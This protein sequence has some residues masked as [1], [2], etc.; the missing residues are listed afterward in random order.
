MASSRCP[1]ARA[2]ATTP[3]NGLPSVTEILGAVQLTGD[4]SGIAVDVLDA[5]RDRGSAVHAAVHDDVYHCLDEASLPPEVL[6]RVNGWRRFLKDSGYR[7]ILAEGTVISTRWQFCGH[8][9]GVGWIGPERTLLDLKCVATLDPAIVSYQLGGYDLAWAEQRP[10]E[11]FKRYLGL[12]L[13]PD[14]YRVHD[15]TARM[16]QARTVFQAALIVFTARGGK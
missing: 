5:A 3:R 6:A 9:D 1:R 16:P 4:F 2:V 8:L 13:L 15:L 12:Q 14:E 7:P 10:T 11:P